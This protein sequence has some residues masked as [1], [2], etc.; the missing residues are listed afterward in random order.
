MLDEKAAGTAHVAI[1]R[2]TG[3]YGGVNEAQIHVDCIF[4]APEIEVDGRR[5][6]LPAG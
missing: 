3:L 5:L 1:G 6:E 2:N 4:S